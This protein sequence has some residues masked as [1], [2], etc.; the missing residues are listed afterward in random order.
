M[1]LSILGAQNNF[2]Q[3]EVPSPNAISVS[4]KTLPRW[5]P[6][7]P[8]P[9]QC[10]RREQKILIVVKPFHF[11]SFWEMTTV[12][13]HPFVGVRRVRHQVLHGFVA[14]PS[15]R[16]FVLDSFLPPPWPFPQVGV[17]FADAMRAERCCHFPRGIT[18]CWG[19]RDKVATVSPRSCTPILV[20]PWD[21]LGPASGWGVLPC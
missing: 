6:P 16:D 1:L 21:S 17:S 18:V 13:T 4:Q 12:Q 9:Y 5:I 8:Q 15:L 3:E 19:R 7:E 14:N 2:L 10:H 11:C 20:H